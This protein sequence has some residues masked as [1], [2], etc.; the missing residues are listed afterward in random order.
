MATDPIIQELL[1][2]IEP[3][4]TP[5]LGYHGPLARPTGPFA[6]RRNQGSDPHGGFDQ[7]RGRGVEGPITSPVY[8]D[9]GF[10]GGPY[11]KIV[12]HE[13]DPVTG[14]RTGYDIEILHTLSQF[15]TRLDKVEPGQLIGMQGGA[16]AGPQ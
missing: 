7:N 16:G 5:T 4:H 12:I 13:R 9:I 3:Q 8:G 1:D 2:L 10:V 14:A 11:G 6:N 15:V